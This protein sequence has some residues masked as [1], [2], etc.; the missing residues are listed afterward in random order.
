MRYDG[1]NI[2]ELTAILDSWVIDIFSVSLA[3]A[4]LN[5][6]LK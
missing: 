4:L 6:K 5:Y 2:V 1:M 3:L